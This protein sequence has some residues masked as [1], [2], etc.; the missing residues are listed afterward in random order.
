MRRGRSTVG[1]ALVLDP[2]AR[3][4]LATV[5][6][7]GCAGWDVHV[8]GAEPRRKAFAAAS[9]FA[10]HYHRVPS[11]A[12]PAEPFRSALLQVIGRHGIDVVVP[13]QDS[14]IARLQSLGLS[15]PTMPAIDAALDAL[16]DKCD[17]A[18]SCVAAGVMYPE[19]WLARERLVLA[20]GE[21]LIVKPRRTA[22]ADSQ[23]VVAHTGAVVVNRVADLSAAIS[24]IEEVGL[25]AIVQ[26]RVERCDKV[27][28]SV[29]RQGS[30]SSLRFAYRVL[31]ESPPEGGIA[32]ATQTL[33]ADEGI[34]LRALQAAEA[35]CDAAGYQG[36]ANVEFYR[37]RNGDLCLIEVNAR[38]WGSIWFA[39]H[40][41]LAPSARAVDC[42]LGRPPAP[43]A[44]YAAGR[45]F[46]RPTLEL[47]W[48]MSR[49]PE[50]RR[51]RDMLSTV[52]PWD[53]VDALSIDDPLPLLHLGWHL[54]GKLPGQLRD[55][56]R[57]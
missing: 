1:T 15:L 8:A 54:L 20:D 44:T 47:A 32:S 51:R 23:R 28:V 55:A 18:K 34:G 40:L 45:R 7:L 11:A 14:T 43:A 24:G 29:V 41:G 50:R 39:E 35:V 26:R 31:R 9:R 49:S 53:V 42:V 38:V 13:C 17:L 46:H 37:Q 21:E 12:G 3:H 19:T 16:I 10:T 33:P 25:E 36:L 57:T 5:R 4:A 48:L 27:N 30:Q 6:G 56:R 2:A 22:R 52:R